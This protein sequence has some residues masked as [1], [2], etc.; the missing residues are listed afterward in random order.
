MPEPLTR[1]QPTSSIATLFSD[2]AARAALA[3]P[4]ARVTAA[5][6]IQPYRSESRPE[7]PRHWP[8]STAP[9]G[10]PSGIVRQFQL[11]ATA[12][13]ALRR[14]MRVYCE[15]TGIELNRSEFLR[16]LIR[17]L[18][19]ALT[20]HEHAAATVGPVRRSKNDPWLLH[21]RD[22]LERRLA[23]ALHLALRTAPPMG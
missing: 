20:Q 3:P 14:V 21:L 18:E 10:E 17:V 7:P 2:E 5:P 8:V 9:T 1:K 16:A 23:A 12:D 19:H 22:D 4:G 13:A 6:V 11:T 15:A